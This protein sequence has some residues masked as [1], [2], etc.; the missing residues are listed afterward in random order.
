MRVLRIKRAVEDAVS[1]VAPQQSDLTASVFGIV[2]EPDREVLR[3]VVAAAE[4]CGELTWTP[5]RQELHFT[6]PEGPN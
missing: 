3:E 2:N 4:K 6:P 5:F 1:T